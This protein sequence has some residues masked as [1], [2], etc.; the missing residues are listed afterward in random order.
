MATM[1][2]EFRMASLYDVSDMVEEEFGS[3]G[4]SGKKSTCAA[5]PRRSFLVRKIVHPVCFGCL[6]EIP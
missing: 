3:G 5:P 1:G 6:G 2:R 4:A